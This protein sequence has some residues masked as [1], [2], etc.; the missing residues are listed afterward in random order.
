[1]YLCM[2]DAPDQV[3]LNDGSGNFIDTGQALGSNQGSDFPD[4][5]DVD[6]DGDMDVVVGTGEGVKIWLNQ[7]NTGTF[8]EAGDY[9]GDKTFKPELFD[10]DLDGDLDLI[11]SHK[12]IGNILWLNDGSGNFTSLGAIF[13][14]AYVFSI[15]T[16]DLDGDG[17]NDVVF[18]QEENS[19]GNAIYMKE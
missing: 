13:G 17:D 7:D 19:G 10:A 4:G 11:T 9:F 16:G 6:G 5:G 12:D 18:G 8:L 1:L 3:W 2:T 14:N 15:G